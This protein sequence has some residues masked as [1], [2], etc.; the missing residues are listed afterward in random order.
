MPRAEQV[1]GPVAEH[2]EGPLWWVGW[3]GLRWVDMLA[4]DVLQLAADGTV[5]RQHVGPVA[6]A[7]RPRASG[8]A[9]VALERCFAVWDEGAGAPRPL[10]DLWDDPGIR[11]N[12]GGCDPD[13]RFYCGSMSYA[14]TPDRGSMYRLNPDLTTERVLDRVTISN[15]LDWSPDGHTAYYVDS[16]QQRIDV[17]DYAAGTGLTARLGGTARRRR[18]TPVPARR[19]ARR[20]DRRPR[21]S[22]NRLYLRR[23]G[24][25]LPLHHHIAPGR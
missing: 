6:A 25:R 7:I 20:G 23:T 3:G 22:G 17:F 8:G 11:F 4:G 19:P 16:A 24:S 10:A 9:V 14:A 1:T 15:G 18:G 5:G 2:G 21:H 12:E 13:G